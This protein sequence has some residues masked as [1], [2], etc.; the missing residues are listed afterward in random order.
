[1]S[2]QLGCAGYSCTGAADAEIQAVVAEDGLPGLVSAVLTA[3]EAVEVVVEVVA[4]VEEAA[5]V[6]RSVE[7]QGNVYFSK[8]WRG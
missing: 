1:V 7:T 5:A 2:T 8:K 6:V 4:A 3:P